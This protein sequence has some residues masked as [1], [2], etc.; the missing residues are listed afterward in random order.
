[1]CV[2]E[3]PATRLC[4]VLHAHV[5]P[6]AGKVDALQFPGRHV[7]RGRESHLLPVAKIPGLHGHRRDNGRPRPEISPAR[8]APRHVRIHRPVI[9]Q[10]RRLGRR[11]GGS[12]A[13]DPASRRVVQEGT[14]KLVRPQLLDIQVEHVVLP[15][16][17]EVGQVG[18]MNARTVEGIAL[19]GDGPA[20]HRERHRTDRGRLGE[21]N[22]Q[23]EP[24]GTR[25]D[26]TVRVVLAPLRQQR[27]VLGQIRR[28][29]GGQQTADRL[30]GIERGAQR[31]RV[32]RRVAREGKRLAVGGSPVVQQPRQ[33]PAVE[34]DR[35][36]AVSALRLQR[37]ASAID[38]QV[39]HGLP[40]PRRHRD[41][42][43][44]ARLARDAGNGQHAVRE[45]RAPVDAE[46]QGQL[47]IGEQ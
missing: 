32:G 21:W 39:L 23:P 22:H 28:A 27:L 41:V 10:L 24:I 31:D 40:V 25:P 2:P 26:E 12:H 5:L 4:V 34:P 13:F 42:R 38:D 36:P 44:L 9:N 14:Q 11:Q 29:S 8:N 43:D 45:L 46:G 37:N 35:G 47:R 19:D 33:A 20:V 17:D 16:L 7:H 3:Y 15:P 1:M 6:G 30:V 18:V